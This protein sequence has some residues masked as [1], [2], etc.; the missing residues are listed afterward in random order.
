MERIPLKYILTFS[1]KGTNYSGWQLQPKS[2]SVQSVINQ[3]LQLLLKEDIITYGAGR[4]DKG[5]HASFFTAHFTSYNEMP[6]KDE[7]FLFR[8]NRI[9]PKDIF[10]YSVKKTLNNFHA[11]YSAISRTYQYIV[12]RKKTCFFNEF[13]TYIYGELDIESMNKAA[14]ILKEY[15]DF[16]S[17]ARLYGSPGT[18][19]CKIIESEW[20]EINGFLI[21]KITANRFLRNMVRAIAGTMLEIGTGKRDI[22][23]FRDVIEKKDRSAAGKSADAKGL[24]LTDITYPEEFGIEKIRQDFPGFLII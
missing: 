7:N 11:R 17:F 2:L 1:Y 22:Q 24:F 9:L 12:A 18:N 4:T 23:E 16:T 3:S 14:M 15:D 13:S 10:V 6:E 20:T 19:I 8:L 21:Y 5:V